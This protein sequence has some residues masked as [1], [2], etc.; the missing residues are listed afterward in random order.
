MRFMRRSRKNIFKMSAMVVILN[1]AIIL[2]T[3]VAQMFHHIDQA[4]EKENIF[5]SWLPWQ[6][7]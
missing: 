5:S 1:I 7:F 3:L 2:A 4:V 6:P